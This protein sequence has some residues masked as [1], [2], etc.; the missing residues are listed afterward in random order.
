[1]SLERPRCVQGIKL[2]WETEC[3]ITNNELWNPWAEM[4]DVLFMS[5]PLLLYPPPEIEP[6]Y[7]AAGEAPEP[8]MEMERFNVV[9]FAQKVLQAIETAPDRDD[10]VRL[11]KSPICI[12]TYAG[13]LSTIY[14]A[15]E[16]GFSKSRG[17]MVGM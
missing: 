9:D 15:F 11:C 2:E 5:H 6:D 8:E 16:F 10:K 3:P 7:E 1:M 13:L 12:R 14:N 17:G 4:P